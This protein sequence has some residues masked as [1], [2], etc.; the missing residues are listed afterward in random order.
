MVNKT[1]IRVHVGLDRGNKRR[2]R[3]HVT[4]KNTPGDHVALTLHGR[5]VTQTRNQRIMELK[6]FVTDVLQQITDGVVDA[7]KR[8]VFV[9]P[10]KKYHGV[11]PNSYH[12]IDGENYEESLQTVDFEVGLT[13]EVGS[14]GGKIGVSLGSFS[15]GA[16]GGGKTSNSS[17]T[18]IRFSIPMLLPVYKSH[19]KD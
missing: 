13:N 9:N 16:D 17:V 14:G 2:F 4:H 6:E 18:R 11:T 3:V 12:T 5:P 10:R 7:Q 19:E 1:P 8:G 15:F